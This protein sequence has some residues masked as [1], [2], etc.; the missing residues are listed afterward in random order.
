LDHD[1]EAAAAATTTAQLAA[2]V[3]S[4]RSTEAVI[5]LRQRLEGHADSPPVADFLAV[6]DTLF[7]E[8]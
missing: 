2:S 3:R 1:L 6:A 8:W 7:P 4:S 5:D